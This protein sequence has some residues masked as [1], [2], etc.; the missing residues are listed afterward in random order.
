MTIIEHQMPMKPGEDEFPKASDER[1]QPFY[2]QLVADG[3]MDA[4]GLMLR[5]AK[6]RR[7]MAGNNWIVR[8]EAP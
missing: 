1:L 7:G 5:P 8:V 4:K 3:I 2:K 6:L